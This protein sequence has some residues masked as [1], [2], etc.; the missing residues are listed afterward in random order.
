MSYPKIKSARA[1]DNH[2]LL[3]EFDNQE[4]KWYDITPLLNRE[5]FAPLHNPAFFKNVQVE[6]SGHAVYWNDDIDLS[7][8]E[9]WSK[10]ETFAS[11]K[12]QNPYLLSA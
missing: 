9:L 5:M 4:R 12:Q 6:K 1:I 3:V 7:E 2:T 8:Y 10:G 11:N